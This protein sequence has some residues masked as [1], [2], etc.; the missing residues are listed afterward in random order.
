[1]LIGA[2]F[3]LRLSVLM[4]SWHAPQ[5]VTLQVCEYQGQKCQL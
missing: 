2:V 5:Q 3:S 1:M 4:S